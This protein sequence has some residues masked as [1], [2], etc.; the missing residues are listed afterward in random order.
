MFDAYMLIMSHALFD[1]VGASMP[2]G[3]TWPTSPV[4]PATPLMIAGGATPTGSRTA[5][6]WLIVPLGSVRMQLEEETVA[7]MWSQTL[8]MMFP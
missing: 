7:S 5:R 2:L 8:A 6:G 3:G 4:E 1:V